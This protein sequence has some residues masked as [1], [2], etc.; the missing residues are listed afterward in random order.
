MLFANA[1]KDELL[2]FAKFS[3]GVAA[4]E[5]AFLAF[6]HFRAFD[7]RLGLEL[8]PKGGFTFCTLSLPDQKRMF[9]GVAQC[10]KKDMFNKKIGREI[11][12]GR[13]TTFSPNHFFEVTEVNDS[14]PVSA[15]LKEYFSAFGE[16]GVDLEGFEVY[17][18]E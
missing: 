14:E 4:S 17:R 6:R 12:F 10:S 11:A 16:C 8:S 18:P 13:L 5:P 7:D 9:V 3:F 1:D 2:N 15:V